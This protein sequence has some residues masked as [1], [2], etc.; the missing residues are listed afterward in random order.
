PQLLD[1]LAARFMAEGWS[2]KKLQRLIMLSATYRQSSDDNPA[3]A[4]IDPGNQL[5][6]RMNRQRLEF[7]AMRDTMLAVAGKLD[8]TAGGHA[9]E[10]T[11]PTATRRTVYG[12][13]DRQN[14]PDLFRTFDFA[15]PDTSS[16]RRFYT[17]VPQ[18]A[19]FLMNSPFV[20]EQAKNLVNRPDFKAAHSEQEQLRLLYELAFQRE[21]TAEEITLA[22][23]FTEAQAAVPP[24]SGMTNWLF[25]Y[26]GFDET[27]KRVKKFRKLPFF[28]GHAFQ[29]GPVLPD[30]KLGWVVVNGSGG[31]P[32]NDQQH[33]SIRRW[34][35]PCDGTISITGTLA[36]PDAQGD[37]VRGRIVSSES[38]MLG[39]WL[40]HNSK[41]E[42]N[43]ERTPVKQGDTIDFVTDCYGNVGFDSF[44]WSPVIRFVADGRTQPGQ[45]MEW[46]ALNDFA[47][48]AKGTTLKLDAWQ[49]YAQVLLLA[50]ELV[51]V[52]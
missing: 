1:Y 39:Q 32:G 49:K 7:E 2:V 46:N 12:Y 16:A 50:N 38:G 43:L 44:S 9:V 5:I 41:E 17:T 35:A 52:D 28:D 33:A 47:E 13:I 40:V 6:W 15:S 36:H 11:E 42:T 23:Q 26:G 30:P 48:A 31:H 8:L 25:G 24:S 19:L 29:G 20:I 14:L 51:F 10:I 18:Q 22:H 45:R 34:I 3:C 37:G 4:K 27:S 21:P